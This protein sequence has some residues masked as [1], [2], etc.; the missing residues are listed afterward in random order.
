M[1]SKSSTSTQ[2]MMMMMSCDLLSPQRF[3]HFHSELGP[4][5]Y[6]IFCINDFD[7]AQEP[8]VL[9]RF[10]TICFFFN[11]CALMSWQQG[12]DVRIF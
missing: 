7:V 12:T 9:K 5:F 8:G 1:S 2:S 10:T 4:I 3:V 11:T 6:S